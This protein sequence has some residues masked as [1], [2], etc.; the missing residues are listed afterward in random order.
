MQFDELEQRVLAT[1]DEAGAENAIS[2]L[3]T[4]VSTQGD[5]GEIESY[6]HAI[7]RL[8][9]TN[10]IVIA[11]EK[12]PGAGLADLEP[13]AAPL[14]MDEFAKRLKFDRSAGLWVDE[15]RTG[16]PF[17]PLRPIVVASTTGRKA[18]RKIVDARG[19]SW[20]FAKAQR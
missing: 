5:A 8:A 16:P 6:V 13:D 14:A 9:L 20:W 4:T 17:A 11:D 15:S 7:N 18:A 19:E 10:F 3:N 2:L 12:E 1:L